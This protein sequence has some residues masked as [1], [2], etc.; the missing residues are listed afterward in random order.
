MNPGGTANERA[1]MGLEGAPLFPM[2]HNTFF[3]R[4]MIYVARVPSK[5]VHWTIIQ[6][7]GAVV[8]GYPTFTQAVYRYGGQINGNLL[9]SNY[10]TKP[11]G[12]SDCAQRSQVP[13]PMNRWACV[14]W[15]FDGE[16]KELDFWLDG[17]IIPALSVRQKAVPAQGACQNQSW[18]GI[19]EPPIFDAIRVGWQHYQQGPGEAWIDDVA[20]DTKRVGCPG[21]P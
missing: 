17:T 10:D 15:R 11:S 16:N 8:P 14:E 13:V 2:P 18:S 7:E 6:G 20:I 12:V 5:T 21:A 4:M 19:W 1:V 9:M 3:G